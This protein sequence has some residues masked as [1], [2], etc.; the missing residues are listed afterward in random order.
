MN[1]PTFRQWI[2][3]EWVGAISGREWPLI[4]PATEEVIE[5][6]PFGDERDI[7]LAIDVAS[8][9]FPA[10]AA[11]TPYERALY[12]QRAADW[13][14][15]NL[16]LCARV[17]T[18]ES[19][20]PYS[21]ALAEWR[22]APNYL[23]W[24]AE[25]GKRS[26]GRTIP[27]RIP[28]R[29][30]AVNY[31]PLGVVA[32]ITAWNFPVYNCVRA[33]SS[34]LAAGCTVIGRPS[35]FTPRSAM[36]L[37]HAFAH[38]GLPKGV[39][40][41]VNGDPHS[42][43]QALLNDRRV[44]K[45]HFTGSTRVGRILLEGSARTITRLSLELGGNAPLIAFPDIKNLQQF[46]ETAVAWKLR[47]CGQVC[48]TPQRFFIHSHIIEPFTD[49]AIQAMKKQVVGNGLQA[50]VTVGPLINAVQ[51][52]RV[53]RIVDATVA[54]GGELLLGGQR[55]DMERGYFYQPTVMA[56]IKDEMTLFVEEIFGPIL[57]IIPFTE[58]DEVIEQANRSELGL[59]AFV[60]THDLD[61]AIYVA[62][63]LEYGMVCINDW[64]PA[65]PEAPFGGVKQS[66]LGRESGSEGLLEY[67]EPKTTFINLTY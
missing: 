42:M 51:R 5:M 1:Q 28:T 25:E 57:P 44:R 32:T 52:D 35:E 18:E 19:G 58:T 61:R 21:E 17:T 43:G 54:E 7:A 53:E 55:S 49:Y 64:L 14:V 65:T 10:W 39:L 67:L 26:Y 30:I 11:K 4:N 31:Q 59:T 38:A 23:I 50:G 24:A 66:G 34:A 3:G 41:V 47:N 29:R 33:W 60:H 37:A 46:A 6:I 15:A 9:A 56:N 8:A 13:L 22:S 36:L 48:V 20:K 2:D 62:E 27:A 16:E 63:K 40:N 45:I 12:L